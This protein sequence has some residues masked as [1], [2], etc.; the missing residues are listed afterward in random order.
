MPRPKGRG[1]SAQV[2]DLGKSGRLGLAASAGAAAVLLAVDALAVL[3][4]V[5]AVLALLAAGGLAA[6]VFAAVTLR[7]G[8]E[9]GGGH[10]EGH[11]EDQSSKHVVSLLAGPWTGGRG[12]VT[13]HE[14]TRVG[15]WRQGGARKGGPIE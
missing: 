3:A 13:V 1:G 4:A 6:L 15:S 8:G 2:T 11:G 14:T 7:G 12:T 9:S 5:L 10:G